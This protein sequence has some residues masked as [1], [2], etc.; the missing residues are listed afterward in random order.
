M[1]EALVADIYDIRIIDGW[2]SSREDQGKLQQVMTKCISKGT[3]STTV[4]QVS[5]LQ[6]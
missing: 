1:V 3:T 5:S 2:G 4:Q 6:Q